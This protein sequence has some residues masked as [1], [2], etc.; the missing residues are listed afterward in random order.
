[1]LALI[2]DQATRQIIGDMH[3][4]SL[5]NPNVDNR[6]FTKIEFP[7][8]YGET[9]TVEKDPLMAPVFSC[10]EVTEIFVKV[11]EY[12]EVKPTDKKVVDLYTRIWSARR[13]NLVIASNL[14]ENKPN[15]FQRS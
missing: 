9:G 13:A 5:G 7:L 2:V 14:P 8:L 15:P 11:S 3:V 6:G 12:M 1:M 4:D 10:I